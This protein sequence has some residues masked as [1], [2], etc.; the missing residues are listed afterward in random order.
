VVTGAQELRVKESDRIQTMADGLRAL[1][2]RAEP[3]LD[4]MRVTGGSYHGGQVASRGDHR[5]AMA[6]A[7]AGLRATTAVTVTDCVNVATSFPGFVELAGTAGLKI[8]AN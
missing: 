2:A 8:R 1:G 6:F 4:G 7:V 5:V 3:T